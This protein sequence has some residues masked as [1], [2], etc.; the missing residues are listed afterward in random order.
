MILIII[1]P[2]SYDNEDAYVLEKEHA[3]K[4]S[5]FLFIPQPILSVLLP[6]PS[7][8]IRSKDFLLAKEPQHL[9]QSWIQD[10]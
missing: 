3:V 6:N 5:L 9:F 8:R 7:F 10:G 1:R 2:Q 4:R